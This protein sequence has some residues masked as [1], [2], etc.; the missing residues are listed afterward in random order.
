MDWLGE[1]F[2]FMTLSTGFFEQVG[3]GSLAGKKKNFTFWKQFADFNGSF[4]ASDTA[5][6][7]IANQHVRLP[8]GGNFNGL[9]AAVNSASIKTASV[10]DDGQSIRDHL[11][12]I[13]DQHFRTWCF[14]VGGCRHH[15]LST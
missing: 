9:F 15:Y 4:D 2:K 11:L 7:D 13:C 10:E 14:R 3:G 8:F 6:D 12:V 1:N 5:H